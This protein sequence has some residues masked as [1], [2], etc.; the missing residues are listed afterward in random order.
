MAVSFAVCIE[1]PCVFLSPL[2]AVPFWLCMLQPD[3]PLLFLKFRSPWAVFNSCFGT[4]CSIEMSGRGRLQKGRAVA[5]RTV[6]TIACCMI[7]LN[8]GRGVQRVHTNP[9]YCKYSSTPSALYTKL[10]HLKLP[11]GICDNRQKLPYA[12][13]WSFLHPHLACGQK[14]SH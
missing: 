8:I 6:G 4:V 5:E 2:A 13:C 10:I 3:R 1:R 11:L 14:H 9:H 7:R 12:L